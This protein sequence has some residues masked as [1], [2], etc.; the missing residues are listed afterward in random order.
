MQFGIFVGFALFLTERTCR[1]AKDLLQKRICP[2][3]LIYVR[4]FTGPPLRCLRVASHL[5]CSDSL[6][7]L[8]RYERRR[9]PGSFSMLRPE[10]FRF[11]HY[12][13]T[14]QISGMRLRVSNFVDNHDKHRFAPIF[15]QKPHGRTDGWT[16]ELTDRPSYI[17][18]RGRI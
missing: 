6:L 8:F 5:T 1:V 12:R 14:K 17:D 13:D 18:I 10:S 16:A 7:R 2:S 11:G 3:V 15:L 9:L 4:T